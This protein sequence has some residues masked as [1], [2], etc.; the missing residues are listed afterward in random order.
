MYVCVAMPKC[1]GMIGK[2]SRAGSGKC[3]GGRQFRS[4]LYSGLCSAMEERHGAKVRNTMFAS[5]P[6][7]SVISSLLFK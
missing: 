7:G 5:D 3:L 2:L 6:V 4:P 1:K